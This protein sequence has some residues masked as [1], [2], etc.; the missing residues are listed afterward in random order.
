MHPVFAHTLDVGVVDA[1][2]AFLSGDDAYVVHTGPLPVDGYPLIDGRRSVRQIASQ[3]AGV[4]D[5]AAVGSALERLAASGVIAWTPPAVEQNPVEEVLKEAVDR[6]QRAFDVDVIVAGDYLDPAAYEAGASAWEAGAPHLFIRPYGRRPLLGPLVMPGSTPCFACLHARLSANRPDRVFL[7]AHAGRITFHRPA[8][9]PLCLPALTRVD[10]ELE[11]WRHTGT[12]DLLGHV[13]RLEPESDSETH[14]PI[15]PQPRCPVCGDRREPDHP[16]PVSLSSDAGYHAL[17]GGYRTRPAGDTL[18]AYRHL[19]DRITGIVRRLERITEGAVPFVHAYKAFHPFRLQNYTFDYL[20]SNLHPPSGGKGRT[21]EEARTS[22]LCEAI[23]RYSGVYHGDEYTIEDSFDGLGDRAIHPNA[24]MLFSDA[25]YR[26]R[27]AWNDRLPHFCHRVPEP[28]DPAARIAWSPLWSLTERRFKYLPAAYCYFAYEGP[29]AAFCRA[30]SNGNA[31]GNTPE[32]AILQG[33]LELVERDALAIWWYNRARRPA[34]DLDA[35]D[36]PYFEALRRHYGELGRELWLLDVTTD[37]NIPV[38]AAVSRSIDSH[39]ENIIL[40]FGAHIDPK[41][42]ATRAL[43]ELNQILPSAEAPQSIRRHAGRSREAASFMD[44][45]ARAAVANH[46]YLAPDPSGPAMR[47]EEVPSFPSLL[48]A[49]EYIL[50]RA[51]AGGIEVLVQDQ[52]RP[53]I[54]LHVVKVVA[55]GLRHHWKRLAPGRLYETPV[56]MGWQPRALDEP[57]LNPVPLSY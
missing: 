38:V 27:A 44:W 31:A 40:G 29:G 10:A 30:D 53:D 8:S 4:L 9:P 48:A 47:L 28:F 1:S 45:L 33:L 2:G 18:A 11:R 5:P 39:R 16:E 15:T 52:T 42:A 56:R 22:A 50:E 54:G 26:G 19:I 3:L 55:P 20:V 43:T 57:H 17:G 37:L 51:H 34:V 32:E 41:I 14:H 35:L 46:P 7:R 49:I 23:E 24:C 6:W 12:T 21:D 25:Q 13:I 36:D